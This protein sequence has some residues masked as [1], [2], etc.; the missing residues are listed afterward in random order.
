MES[1]I[2]R[3]GRKFG[4]TV[5]TV[6]LLA[7]GLA[8]WRGHAVSAPVFGVVAIALIAAA[9]VVPVQLRAIDRAWM[10]LAH[11]ISRVTTP[12]LMALIYFVLLTPIGLIQRLGGRNPLT[13]KAGS[14]GFWVD[15]SQSPASSLERQF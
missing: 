14:R 4:L 8:R 1:Y 11:L 2:A 13:H 5:G 7:A 6:F 12:I 3:D 10:G 9:L 15:R